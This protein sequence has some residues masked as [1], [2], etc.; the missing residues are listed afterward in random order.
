MF[1]FRNQQWRSS[2]ILMQ[3]FLF[4]LLIFAAVTVPNSANAQTVWTA[5]P[6]AG[7]Q[8]WRFDGEFSPA[9]GKVFFLGGRE[10]GGTNTNGRVW[11]FDPVTGAYAD[12]GVDMPVPVSNYTIARLTDGSGNELLMIWGGRNAAGAVVNTVQGYNPVT[13]TTVD[14]TA[15]D[16]YPETTSPGSVSVVG[17]KAYSFGGFDAVATTAGCHIF[18]ITAVDGT[19]WPSYPALILSRS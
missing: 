19:R 9:T 17:N 14:F 4:L 15:T 16:P 6:D 12:T 11:S 3:A 13:N 10:V 18:D 2:A 5:G 8:F 7:F 1:D